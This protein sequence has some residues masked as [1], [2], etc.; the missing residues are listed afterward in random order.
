MIEGQRSRALID[1]YLHT[2]RDSDP[3]IGLTKIFRGDIGGGIRFIEEA[4][5]RQEKVGNSRMA[6]GY[7][8]TL[9][10]IYLNIIGGYG[11]LPLPTLL[12]N[13]PIL[14]KVIITASSRIRGFIALMAEDPLADHSGYHHGHTE[15]I[16]GLLYKIKKSVP[17]PLSICSKQSEH[18]PESDKPPHLR[19]SMRLSRN[20]D[21][22]AAD[23][24]SCVLSRCC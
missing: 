4:I 11:Y 2:L 20:W 24:H 7:R 5:Q 6:D 9:C 1:G 22:T 14:L 19:G 16:L 10:E 15:L 23:P 13:L 3:F 8:I 21:N 12:R 18:S 17:S